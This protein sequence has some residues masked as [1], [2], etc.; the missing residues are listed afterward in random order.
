VLALK[1]NVHF[2]DLH[3]FLHLLE[4][5]YC[6]TLSCVV[7][8][9]YNSYTLI[10]ARISQTF[11]R[12]A[13]THHFWYQINSRRASGMASIYDEPPHFVLEKTWDNKNQATRDLQIAEQ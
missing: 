3:L 1:N 13:R 12:E 9:C 8:G 7:T 10:E 6:I 4:Y 2:S 11:P 5:S